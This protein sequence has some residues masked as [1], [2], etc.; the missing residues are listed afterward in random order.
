MLIQRWDYRFRDHDCFAELHDNGWQIRYY[1]EKSHPFSIRYFLN[2]ITGI[3]PNHLQTEMLQTMVAK[4]NPTPDFHDWDRLYWLFWESIDVSKLEEQTYAVDE[5]NRMVINQEGVVIYRGVFDDPQHPP[6][7]YHFTPLHLFYFRCV[8]ESALSIETRL[9]AW[10]SIEAC[11][12]KNSDLLKP[13]RCILIDY[14]KI[15]RQE[16]QVHEEGSN[17]NAGVYLSL[18][19]Y[20]SAGGWSGRDGGG[21]L[22][23][24]EKF[25]YEHEQSPVRDNWREKIPEILER[26]RQAIVHGT[27]N[28]APP[29]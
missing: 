5:H 17:Q 7:P 1:G 13:K 8:G 22:E 18:S 27:P 21:S 15:K 10:K 3:V 4:A 26:I 11:F 14:T 12:S 20:I 16:W 25:W 2:G 28:L 24:Y 9:S 19:S 23:T 6:H 29:A